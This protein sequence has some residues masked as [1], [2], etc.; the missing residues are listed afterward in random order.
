MTGYDREYEGHRCSFEGATTQYA[1]HVLAEHG[2]VLTEAQIERLAYYKLHGGFSQGEWSEVDA[3]HAIAHGYGPGSG[4]ISAPAVVLAKREA[5]GVTAEIPWGS[6][7]IQ[8]V[9]AVLGTPGI[10]WVKVAKTD[11]S[12]IHY[13]AKGLRA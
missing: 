7:G 13:E 4:Y 10:A 12:V 6:E 2:D 8:P 5:D 3:I 11:G 1:E 9:A